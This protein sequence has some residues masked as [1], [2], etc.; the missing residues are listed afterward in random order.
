MALVVIREVSCSVWRPMLANPNH[1]TTD[2]ITPEK[3]ILNK[4]ENVKLKAFMIM[5]KIKSKLIH[6]IGGVTK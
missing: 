1:A 4:K 2:V 3:P 5:N 6:W